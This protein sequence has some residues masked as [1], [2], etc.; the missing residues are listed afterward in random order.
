MVRNENL[1]RRFDSRWTRRSLGV[2]YEIGLAESLSK[3]ILCLVKSANRESLSAM[4]AGNGHV[5]LAE[6]ATVDEARVQIDDFMKTNVR[7]PHDTDS[8]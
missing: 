2:G 4:I 1:L 5:C 6:Y 8:Y 7:P 3:P